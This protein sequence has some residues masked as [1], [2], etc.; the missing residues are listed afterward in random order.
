MPKISVIMGV[1]NC[2]NYNSLEKSINSIINQSYKN[3]E[4][5]ICNDGSTN[6]TLE[7]L[8]SVAA[9]DKRIKVISYEKNC[10]LAAALNYCLKFAKGEYIARQDDDDD[11]SRPDRFEKQLNFLIQNKNY[12]FVG[13]T[14][15][16]FDN[17]G[18][19]GKLKVPKIVTKNDFLWN[20]PFVHPTVIFSKKSL[21]LVN[22]Y[23]IAKETKRCEDYDLFMRMYAKGFKGYNIQEDLYSYK[24]IIDKNKKYRPMKDRIDEAIVRYKGYKAMGILAKGIPFIIKPILIALIPAKVFAIIKEFT[25]KYI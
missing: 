2:K 5:I 15:I 22:G 13:S 7:M 14:C 18:I 11:I 17:N 4:F 24:S 16:V 3:W 19:Y 20:N 10:G 25:Y 12:D 6:N 21:Q 8:N 9:L 1:Y 23:R